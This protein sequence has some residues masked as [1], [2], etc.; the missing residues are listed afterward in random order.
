[1]Q[2]VLSPRVMAPE[3]FSDGA[4]R[5]LEHSPHIP[6]TVGAEQPLTGSSWAIHESPV[7][8]S[9][10]GEMGAHPSTIPPP[11]RGRSRERSPGPRDEGFGLPGQ[12]YLFAASAARSKLALVAGDTVIILLVWDEGPR[13]DGLLAA[14]AYE[15]VLVPGLSVVLQLAGPCEKSCAQRGRRGHTCSHWTR[16]AVQD[17]TGSCTPQ[18]GQ[19]G[20]RRWLGRSPQV[21]LAATSRGRAVATCPLHQHRPRQRSLL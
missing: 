19:T 6:G 12:P 17:K 13:P 11:L 16:E 14:A 21:Q 8:S 4:W 5:G 10:P 20:P 15:A 3:P 18:H 7:L 2:E 1:M 9:Q